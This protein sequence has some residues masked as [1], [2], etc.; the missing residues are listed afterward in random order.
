MLSRRKLYLDLEA[1][2]RYA[3]TGVNRSAGR[4]EHIGMQLAF[5][6]F[7]IDATSA[8]DGEGCER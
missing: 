7:K 6:C 1:I 8:S 5:F 2:F 3:E 4:D